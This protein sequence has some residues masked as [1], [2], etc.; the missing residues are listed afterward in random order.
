[1]TV[2]F[3][4]RELELRYGFRPLMIYENIAGKTFNPSGLTDIVYFFYCCLLASAFR[5]EGDNIEYNDFLDW[6][7]ENP[8]KLNEF[9]TWLVQTLTL[10]K[11]IS[12]KQKKKESD[13]VKE[14][15]PKN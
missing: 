5:N 13:E 12:P 6:L 3:K 9:S 7:D 2:D 11:E 1:M 14:V 10:Q 4:G 8:D 15:N